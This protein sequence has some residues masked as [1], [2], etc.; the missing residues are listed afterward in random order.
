MNNRILV[1]G[2]AGFIGYHLANKLLESDYHIDL[3]DNFSRGVNDTQLADLVNNEKI[4]LIN[5]CEKK[6]EILLAA[7]PTQFRQNLTKHLT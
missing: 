6:K 4:N 3:L 2:A 5:V 1:T 7:I